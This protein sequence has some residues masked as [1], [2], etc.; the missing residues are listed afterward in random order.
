MVNI[1]GELM[2][3]L[4]VSNSSFFVHNLI[5][6]NTFDKNAL[7]DTGVVCGTFDEF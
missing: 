1:N 5:L 2:A 6:N 3:R 4:L 7:P